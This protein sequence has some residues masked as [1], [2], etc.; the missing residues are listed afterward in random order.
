MES[1]F[2]ERL[3]S[4]LRDKLESFAA[5]SSPVEGIISEQQAERGE[6]EFFLETGRMAWSGS[7]KTAKSVDEM[8]GQAVRDGRRELVE[9]LKNTPQRDMVV[10]RLT[11]QFSEPLMAEVMRLLAPAHTDFFEDLLGKLGKLLNGNFNGIT[12]KEARALIRERLLHAYLDS[13]SKNNIFDPERLFQETMRSVF[14]QQASAQNASDIEFDNIP[15]KTR[16]R[17]IEAALTQGKAEE[18]EASWAEILRTEGAQIREIFARH[19]GTAQA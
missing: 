3:R 1:R 15:Q 17:Q 10:Q 13:G 16:Q 12:E 8:L 11:K 2:K 18:I 9:F 4:A 7:H 5:A 6:L 14:P 19:L